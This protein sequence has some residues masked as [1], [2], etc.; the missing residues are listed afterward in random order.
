MRPAVSSTLLAL[1]LSAGCML[2]LDPDDYGDPPVDGGD[3]SVGGTG[4]MGG[5]TSA[6]G[7]G[8]GGGGGVVDPECSSE[9]LSVDTTWSR[10]GDADPG[11]V[12]AI[13]VTS[14]AAG[15]VYLLG[16]CT[17]TAMVAGQTI[18]CTDGETMFVLKM[19]PEGRSHWHKRIVSSTLAPRAVIAVAADGSRIWVAGGYGAAVDG[20]DDIAVAGCIET[21]DLA[22]GGSGDLFVAQLNVDG[23]CQ[24]VQRHG[25]FAGSDYVTDLAVMDASTVAV[26]G[27]FHDEMNIGEKTIA[28]SLANGAA[29]AATFNDDGIPGWLQGFDAGNVEDTDVRVA[30]RSGVLVAAGTFD[31]NFAGSNV[32]GGGY[33]DIFIVPLDDKEAGAP[34]TA[35]LLGG[36]SHDRL[37]DLTLGALGPTVLIGFQSPELKVGAESLTADAAMEAAV[38][39][40]SGS[41]G[42]RFAIDLDGSVEEGS[43]MTDENDHDVVFTVTSGKSLTGTI[44]ANGK[45]VFIG[46]VGCAGQLRWID[47]F[48]DGDGQHAH[49]VTP[50]PEGGAYLA[51]NFLGSIDFG[52]GNLPAGEFTD[53]FV[54]HFAPPRLA[55]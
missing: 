15:N 7:P 46:R 10:T 27:R 12:H 11:T 39:G 14:D 41:L 19:S 45:D 17:G 33:S 43:A 13:D 2:V 29:F 16:A 40:L 36:S 6:T 50:A 31:G 26:V 47:G 52:Q 34:G 28:T 25:G 8:A 20:S 44:T 18:D 5:A 30:Y 3:T 21:V 37:L 32:M 24:W 55:R 35:V 51:G 1:S 23:A 9:K 48:G 22:D 38:I 49:G 53:V 42:L 54:A 4:G